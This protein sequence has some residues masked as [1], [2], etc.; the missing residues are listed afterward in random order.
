MLP[1]HLFAKLDNGVIAWIGAGVAVLATFI[2]ITIWA[3]PNA[4][5]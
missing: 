2:C 5:R 4:P 1:T 3:A